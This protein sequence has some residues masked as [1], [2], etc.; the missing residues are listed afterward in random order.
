MFVYEPNKSS[1]KVKIIRSDAIKLCVEEFDL[2][3]SPRLRCTLLICFESLAFLS[4]L[5]V[6]PCESVVR[7][8]KVKP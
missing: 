8:R 7:N 2:C 6:A 3:I 1:T 5:R 4:C